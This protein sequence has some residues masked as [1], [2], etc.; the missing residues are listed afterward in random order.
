MRTPPYPR[1]SEAEHGPGERA[2]GMSEARRR[3]GTSCET[4][5]TGALSTLLPGP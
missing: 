1:F 4:S 5:R 3:L 2:L